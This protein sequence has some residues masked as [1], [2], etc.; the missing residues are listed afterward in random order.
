[1]DPANWTLRAAT[2]ADRDFL[3]ELNRAAFRASVEATWGWDEQEQIAF[4]DGRFDPS[5]RQIVQIEGVDVGEV[6]VEERPHEIYLARI[7]LLP[8]W[9]GRGIG[10][11]IVRSLLERAGTDGKSVVLEVLHANARA[12]KLYAELGFAATG[13]SETHLLM[14]AD[15]IDETLRG[16]G[17]RLTW[18][19]LPDDVRHAIEGML[20]CAVAEAESQRGGFSPGVAARLRL[21]DG[22]RV[23][24]KAVGESLNAHAPVLYRREAAVA[25]RLPATVP[26]PRLL[27]TYDEDGWVALVFEDVEA[28]QPHLPWRRNELERVLAALADL[29]RSLTPTPVPLAPLADDAARFGGFQDLAASD[30]PL[31]DLDPWVARNI[32]RL[33]AL[34]DGWGTATAGDTL[35]H[36]DVRAD[37]VLLTG[38][39]VLFVDW[40]HATVGAAW[41]DLVLMLPSVAMQ[42]G[43]PP[44]ELF[45]GY[46][47]A[48]GADAEAVTVVLAG[49]VGFLTAR[50]RLPPPPGLP[51]LRR[52][53]RAQAA[54]GV[55]WLRERTGWP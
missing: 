53:Q 15:P 7:A 30:G 18:P 33:A 11:A 45:A 42:G 31:D 39:R 36:L 37:N 21:T 19:E 55:R 22:R 14:R 43:P 44:W 27:A 17:V 51:T 1:M 54:E 24:V 34:H 6:M 46:P 41:I 9:Q 26:T 50:G 48:S 52:F 2:A 29:S 28:R 40:P 8:E 38:D 5:R 4:F 10:T 12:A 13:R 32:D 25:G 23:F 20:G 3:F 49:F 35:V 47:L 16:V